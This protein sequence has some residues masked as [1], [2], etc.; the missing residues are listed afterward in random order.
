MLAINSAYVVFLELIGDPPLLIFTYYRLQLFKSNLS[1]YKRPKMNQKITCT[2]L[3]Y[4]VVLLFTMIQLQLNTLFV[5][6]TISDICQI[7]SIKSMS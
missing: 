2:A 5:T 3:K 7:N 4:I 6:G 1:F